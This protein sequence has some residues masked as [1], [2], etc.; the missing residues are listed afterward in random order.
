VSPVRR[1]LLRLG[2]AQLASCAV[3]TG[4]FRQAMAAIAEEEAIADATGGPPVTYHRLQLVAMRG[5]RQE[6]L[7]LFE[8]CHRGGDRAWLGATD[9]QRPLVTAA[10]LN[11]GLGDYPAALAAARQAAAHGDLFLAGFSLPE[12]VEAAVRCGERDE[13]VTPWNR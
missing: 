10:V 12:L 2:L 6:A 4:E 7:E 11:N 13:A 8:D 5:R 3:L 1:S 9:R